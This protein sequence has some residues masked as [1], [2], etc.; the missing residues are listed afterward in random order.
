M[1]NETNETLEGIF[2]KVSHFA[3]LARFYGHNRQIGRYK[4]ETRW[5]LI[6]YP[7]SQGNSLRLPTLYL[8]S[9][10]IPSI[11]T[12]AYYYGNGKSETEPPSKPKEIWKVIVFA[13][14]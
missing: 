9:A 8:L 6:Y 5:C 11:E 13:E 14:P 2:L 7:S 12:K 4:K 3:N 1:R 10:V